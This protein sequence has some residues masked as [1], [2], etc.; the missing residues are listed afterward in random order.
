MRKS[1]T[2]KGT[3]QEAQKKIS[4]ANKRRVPH[5]SLQGE[6]NEMQANQSAIENE[7][8]VVDSEIK[9]AEKTIAEVTAQLKDKI[10]QGRPEAIKA[11]VK[12]VDEDIDT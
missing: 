10:P 1:P 5:P 7:R 11:A 4:E 6:V 2:P 9:D 12:S 8:K 3:L